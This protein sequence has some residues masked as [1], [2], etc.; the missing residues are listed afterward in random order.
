V[1]ELVARVRALFSQRVGSVMSMNYS[2]NAKLLKD[3]R[4]WSND[5]LPIYGT[6]IGY[7]LGVQILENY[8]SSHQ[9][10]LKEIYHSLTYSEPQL[11]RRLRQ[12][13]RDGW[14]SITKN[15]EDH[16]N[17]LVS[18]TEKMLST[19]AEYFRLISQLGQEV[20]PIS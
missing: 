7:D 10:V 5:N 17:F 16:R 9:A 3:L 14:I 12:F 11:R 15:S 4:N 8:S 2:H 6:Y 1:S 20:R 19:Y 13:E 18:P